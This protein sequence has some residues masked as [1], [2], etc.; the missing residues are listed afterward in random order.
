MKI[1]LINS[2][3]GPDYLSDLINYFFLDG[4]Y[5]V[6]TNYIPNFLFN[7]PEEKDKLYG[8][9]FTLYGKLPSQIKED[10]TILN[11]SNLKLTINEFD[12]IIFTSIQ[13]TFNNSHI[14]DSFFKNVYENVRVKQLIVVDGEDHSDVDVSIA[15]KSE[16]FKRELTNINSKYAKPISFSF[17]KS[18]LPEEV[19]SIQQKTQILAPMDPRFNSSYVFDETSYFEQYSKSLFATTTKK[20]GWDCMRHYE[21]LSRNTLLYFPGIQE[22]PELT[23]N[24]FPVNLQEEV[25]NRFLK[26]MISSENIDSLE[27]IRVKYN[28]KNFRKRGIKRV[29]TKLSKLNLVQN[30]ISKLDELNLEMQ[31][32]FVS[33][34]T[35]S[36]YKKIFDLN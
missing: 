2:D 36:I 23:M 13:R 22:K 16:Y 30:N 24:Y 6:Y 14:K 31:N 34:G 5:D 9:G 4:N 19:K 35:T 12:K 17:P 10:I 11:E 8:K 15:K 20:A 29:K 1:L 27:K 32:W 28:S 7:N 3:E 33:Y 26:L 25:N 21:I 18:E